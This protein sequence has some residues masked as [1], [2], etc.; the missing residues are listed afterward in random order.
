M[1]NRMGLFVRK[2]QTGS[3]FQTLFVSSAGESGK[4]PGEGL[5]F[6]KIALTDNS[7]VLIFPPS[8]IS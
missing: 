3:P 1:Q 2:E 5:F 6:S 7:Q 4:E 8:K